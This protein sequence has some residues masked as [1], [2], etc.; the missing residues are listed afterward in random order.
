MDTDR[1]RTDAQTCSGCMTKLLIVAG[2]VRAPAWR[3][4]P[5][6]FVSREEPATRRNEQYRLRRAGCQH[7]CGSRA[8]YCRTEG[9][10]V[11]PGL[12]IDIE[13]VYA[14]KIGARA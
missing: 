2:V 8:P 1:C 10:D 13:G 14:H 12:S 7:T 3:H 9:C 5:K 11:T 4:V 6:A